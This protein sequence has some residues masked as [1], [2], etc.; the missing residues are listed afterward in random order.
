MNKFLA[1]LGIC[2]LAAAYFLLM[3]MN[4]AHAIEGETPDE[5]KLTINMAPFNF[6]LL[7]RGRQKGKVVIDLTL[8]VQEQKDSELIRQR[9]PQIR[10]DFLGALTSLS[11]HRFKVNRSIDPDLVTAYLTPF[12]VNRVGEGKAMVFVQYALIT[13]T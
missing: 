3:P 5:G 1:T 2:F 9:L 4:T 8:V 11:H 7:E 12:L 10:S 13:P 6:Q